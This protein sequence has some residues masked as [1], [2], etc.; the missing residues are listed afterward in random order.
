[1]CFLLSFIA[2]EIKILSGLILALGARKNSQGL[3][4]ECTTAGD[5]ELCFAKIS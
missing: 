2:S 4:S 1:M 5:F 3:N